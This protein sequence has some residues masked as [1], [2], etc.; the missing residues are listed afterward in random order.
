MDSLVEI[1]TNYQKSIF[2]G[3]VW[4]LAATRRENSRDARRIQARRTSEIKL[5]EQNQTK[6]LA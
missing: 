6:L 2:I 1:K 5:N 4:G 3:D